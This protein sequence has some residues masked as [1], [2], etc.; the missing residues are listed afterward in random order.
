MKAFIQN[1]KEKNGYQFFLFKLIVFILL[2]FAGDFL[3]GTALNRFY[4][5]QKSGWEYSTKY[6]VEDT[7]ASMLIFGSSRA[8]QQYNPIF[9]EERLHLSCYN[10][11]RDGETFLYQYAMLQ[12]I[13]KR[14][15]PKIILLECEN[16]MFLKSI[17]S[18]ERLATLLPFYKQHPEMREVILLKSPYERLKLLSNMYPYNSLIFKILFGNVG[19]KEAGDINGYLPL[20]GSLDE[21]KR[22]VN[23][24]KNYELDSNKIKYYHSFIKQCKQANVDLYLVCSPYFSAGTGNDISLTMAKESA[25]E[26]NIPFIDLSKGHPLL[27]NSKLYDDTAHVNQT[28]SQILSNIII[29][30][31]ISNGVNNSK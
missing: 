27:N 5:K 4:N 29:D 10:V 21:P 14:Y 6:S 1:I 19:N 22:A 7:K 26:N 17:S 9:F 12:G 23:F 15:R 28:G 11:G 24:A 2:L 3:I 16:T 31:L 20:N 8:Q 30:S 18:Y 13:L 25:A